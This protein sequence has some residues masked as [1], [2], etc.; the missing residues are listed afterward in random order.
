MFGPLTRTRPTQSASYLN[1]VHRHKPHKIPVSGELLEVL[2]NCD[3]F[4]WMGRWCMSNNQPETEPEKM[5][6]GMRSRGKGLRMCRSLENPYSLSVCVSSCL[7]STSFWKRC[8]SNRETNKKPKMEK[9]ARVT[10]K[11]R[12]E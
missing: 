5:R 3:G 9:A 12:K 10:Q 6:G 1:K 8:R 11:R 4:F 2:S 7:R